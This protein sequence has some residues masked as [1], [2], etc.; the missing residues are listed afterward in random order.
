MSDME[1]RFRPGGAIRALDG[2]KLEVLAAPYGSPTDLDHLEEYFSTRTDF[3]LEVGDRR[4]TLY[5]HGFT[6]DK[7]MT[8]KPAP[9]GIATASRVDDK[10]LWMTVELKAG[11]LADR[12]WA[13]AEAGTCRA[14]TGAV[15]YLCRSAKGGEV[16]VWPIGELSLLDEGL[17]RHPVN[18]KAVAMPLRASFKAIDLEF[19]KAFGEDATEPKEEVVSIPVRVTGETTMTEIDVA[20]K[21]ALDAERK[22]IADAEV[23]S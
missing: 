19:P 15:N 5:F 17:G 21:A 13:A 12:V 9:I 20:V 11:R 1:M 10:G 6:P 23:A 4:P 7:Q 22:A 3:M 8:A 2:R 18:D 14:S 16:E